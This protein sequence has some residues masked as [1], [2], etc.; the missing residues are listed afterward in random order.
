MN[1]YELCVIFKPNL[2]EEELKSEF[3]KILALVERFGGAV[4]KVDNWGKRRLAY[5]INKI[6]EGFY[7]F[8]TFS[9]NSETPVELEKRLRIIET[10]LRYLIIRLD[11]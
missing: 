4:D 9:A 6:H 3:D 8:I 5:E 11:A 2:E 1:K 10:L 7:Y